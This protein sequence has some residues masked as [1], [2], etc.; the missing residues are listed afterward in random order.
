MAASPDWMASASAVIAPDAS[1]P[2]PV[3]AVRLPTDAEAYGACHPT[4]GE[5]HD[6]DRA[7]P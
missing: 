4:D 3:L 6:L 7:G 1:D 2:W 5:R